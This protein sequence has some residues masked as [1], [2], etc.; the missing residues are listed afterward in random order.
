MINRRK[1]PQPEEGFQMAPMIDMVFLLLV[2]F[3]CVSS[4]A[5]LEKS[6]EV[7][8]PESHQSEV[9]TEVSDRGIVSVDGDGSVYLGGEKLGVEGLKARIGA[10]IETNPRLQIVV[11]ADGSTPFGEI[12]KVLKACAESGAYE[13]IYATYE[14]SG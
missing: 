4:L 14:A 10:A 13:V 6:V 11:R 1:R 7:D 9:P 2:F 3:M 8:L 5:R 12:R